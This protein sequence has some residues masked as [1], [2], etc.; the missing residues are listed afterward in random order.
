M[1]ALIAR[2]FDPNRDHFSQPQRVPGFSFRFACM[3]G[4]TLTGAC[5]A[6]SPM[7]PTTDTPADVTNSAATL[8]TEPPTVTA[9]ATATEPPPRSAVYATSNGEL[10]VN[11]ETRTFLVAH[12]ADATA[13]SLPVILSFHGDGSSGSS[14]RKALALEAHGREPAIYVYPN[15]SGGIFRYA[16]HEGRELEAA[17]VQ[18]L[19]AQ[20]EEELPVDRSRVYLVGFSG[21][22]TM[23]N[24]LA[25]RLGSNVIRGVGIHSGTLY[26]VD[27]G[28]G[29]HDFVENAYGATSCDLPASLIIW[30]EQD[31]S[32]GTS[33]A[34]GQITR[35]RHVATQGCS[36]ATEDGPVALC[37]NYHSCTRPVSWCPIPALGH[38]AWPDAANAMWQFFRG[39]GKEVDVES[40]L[41]DELEPE[42]TVPPE[43]P[44]PNEFLIEVAPVPQGP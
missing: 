18:S 3:A 4:L 14:I 6:E 9:L 26:P 24:A 11:G 13:I 15:A 40:S 1:F 29:A 44:R 28:G 42:L 2:S 43:Q 41:A 33:F 31:L 12:P 30:G 37:R 23:V 22:A 25:C 20:I 39:I 21:G 19:L 7:P 38:Q 32:E 16:T 17:F 5:G 35:N 10:V 8:T 36:Q 27:S 34:E